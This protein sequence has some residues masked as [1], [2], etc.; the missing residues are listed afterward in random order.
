MNRYVF[1]KAGRVSGE[2]TDVSEDMNNFDINIVD[3]ADGM[4]EESD[5]NSDEDYI[6]ES[7]EET[8]DENDYE[9]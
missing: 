9:E 4:E 7:D 8:D 1:T 6:Q 2:Q 3:C 5:D